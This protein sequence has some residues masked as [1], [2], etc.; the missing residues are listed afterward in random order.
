MHQDDD[1]YNDDHDYDDNSQD[2]FESQYKKY[3][4]FDPD[5][6][7]AWGKMLYD[8][9]NEIVEYPSN[10][11]YIGPK[12]IE[13]FP[14]KSLPVN[15][16]NPGTSKDKYLQ[17]LGSNYQNHQIWK[18]KYFVNDKLYIEYLNHIKSHA[19]HFVL[20]PHYYEGMFD[21]LN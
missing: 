1:N 8:A 6:W 17:Y 7:D 9:L 20:Q 11:W 10:V 16:W 13:G 3:F 15:S 4:K 19:V 12:N 18:T 5:A 2:N 14:K 21:I